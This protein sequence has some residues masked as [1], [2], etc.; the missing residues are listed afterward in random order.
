MFS[1][2]SFSQDDKLVLV[3][4]NYQVYKDV[5]KKTF[6]ILD[7]EDKTILKDLKYVNYAGFSNNL[8]ILDKNNRILYYDKDLK[9]IETPE[10]GINDVCGTVVYFKREIIEDD[11]NYFIEY[12]EDRSIYSEGV[13]KFIVDTIPKENIKD[14]YF[15]N[16]EKTLEYDEN[17]NYPVYLILD[18]IDTFGIKKGDVIEYFDS[19]VLKNDFTLKVHIKD[20]CGYYGIT[21]IIYKN[22]GDFE[23]NLASFTDQNGKTGY[24]DL[25]GNE[26]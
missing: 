26:Y 11:K 8:Q 9:R 25:L 20:S 15:V 17:F 16:R 19:V 22:L 21:D 13:K 18:F 1:I 23:Y 14:I 3:F 2:S 5:N 7:N 6:K 24:V 4:H 10:D 12:T